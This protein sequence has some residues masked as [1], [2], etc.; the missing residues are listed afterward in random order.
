[1]SD[2]RQSDQATYVCSISKTTKVHSQ[3]LIVIVGPSALIIE[4]VTPD[5]KIHGIERQDMTIKCTAVGGQPPPDTKLIILGSTYIGKQSAMFTFKPIRSNDGANVTCQ[6]GYEGIKSYSLTT[7]ANIH[8]KLKPVI[9]PFSLDT[10]STEETKSFNV[11]CRSTGSR[12]A[13]AMNWFLEQQNITSNSTSQSKKESSTDKYTVT[14]YLRYSVDRRYN[15][16]KLSCRAVNIAGFM[17]GSL[18][19]N[20]KYAPGVIVE[21]KT[22]SQTQSFRQ[23]NSTVDSNPLVNTCTWRHKSK[24]GENIRN[25]SDNNQILTLPLVPA[26]Q[27]YQDTGEYVCTGKNGINGINGQLKQTGSGY[28][29]SYAP[30]VITADNNDNSIQYGKFGSSTDIKVN[31][32]SIA[33]YSNFRWYQI[34]KVLLLSSKYITKE[35]PAIVKDVF[36]GVEVQLDGY[37]ITLT[38]INLQEADF[39]N[40][41][42]RLNHDSQ[43]VQHEVTLESAS[44]PETP[45]NFTI[46]S[47]SET[48]ITVQWIPGHDGGQTQKFHIEYRIIGSSKWLLQEVQN[49]NQI[50]SR[51]VY[52]LTG[53]QDETSYELRMYAQN[54]FNQSQHTDIEAIQTLKSGIS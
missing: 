52:T 11:S 30:P 12:P 28:V 8:L 26:D 43:S 47:S 17:E 31:V 45:S 7:S 33:K 25:F 14:S 22:F 3:Q 16:Q 46:I 34:N 9:D 38:I 49:S 6:A 5:N 20:V 48:S 1:M 23:I 27:R 42:L 44:A 32:Y 21:N 54:K 13:A 24:Y 2:I 10:L 51:M 18:T 4:N 40:Y 37:R 29:I 36:H 53:F 41:T 15:G 19:L 50:Y 35:E 39:T